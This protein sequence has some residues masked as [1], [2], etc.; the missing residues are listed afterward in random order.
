[1][2][3]SEV[4]IDTKRGTEKESVAET[5]LVRP[6]G[7][8]GWEAIHASRSSTIYHDDVPSP[9]TLRQCQKE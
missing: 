4:D 6:K 8:K 9:E 2:A 1:M 3:E 7:Q 5:I